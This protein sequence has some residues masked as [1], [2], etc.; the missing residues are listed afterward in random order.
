MLPSAAAELAEAQLGVIARWQLLQH[1]SRGTLDQVV[2]AGW[3]API[4]RGVLR[5]VGGAPLPDQVPIA[6]ALRCRPLATVTGP[7]VLS[8]A[9][10][11]GFDADAPFEILLAPGRRIA[12]DL[13][14]P[15]RTDPHPA[16]A[17]QLLGQVRLAVLVD[18]LIDAGRF[19]DE[20]GERNLRLAYDSLRWRGELTAEQFEAAL[21]DRPADDPGA[22]ALRE[23]F[24]VADLRSE[25]EGERRIGGAA[26]RFSPAPEP[27]VWVTRTRRVDW[28]FRVLKLALEYLG[29]VD[30]STL[31]SRRAD[32][33][34]NR[35]LAEAGIRVETLRAADVA[36]ED[37]LI[38]RIAA[39][40]A[41]RAK[42]LGVPAPVFVG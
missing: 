7:Y 11:D 40:L 13:G 18:A 42:E 19:V 26:C 39:L 41:L 37:A 12:A 38:A 5:V 31:R 22:A 15:Y 10:I 17:V 4:E 8:R 23:V 34:R 35:E 32:A 25:S 6:A 21:A 16:R 27:Q 3:L 29:S 1:A 33:A 20:V 9:R 36:D 24:G 14:F 30:H 28:Y 2:R